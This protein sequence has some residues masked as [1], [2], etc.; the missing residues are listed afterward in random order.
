[1]LVILMRSLAMMMYLLDW[2]S[3]LTAKADGP[4]V[5]VVGSKGHRR[6]FL[7]Q[8]RVLRL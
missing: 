2:L 5:L 6:V 4:L 8:L 1:M 7:N 3:T